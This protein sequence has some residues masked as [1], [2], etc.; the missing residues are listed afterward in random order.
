[1]SEAESLLWVALIVFGLT[2][3]NLTLAHRLQRETRADIA[4]YLGETKRA[5][6]LMRGG[7]PDEALAVLARA[8][9]AAERIKA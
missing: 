4:H 1:M 9:A 7:N 6:A 5:F 2:A 3:R 8:Q